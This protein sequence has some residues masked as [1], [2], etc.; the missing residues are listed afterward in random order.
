VEVGRSG[1]I[2]PPHQLSQFEAIPEERWSLELTD[3]LAFPDLSSTVT[4]PPYSREELQALLPA[5]PAATISIENQDRLAKAVAKSSHE[6]IRLVNKERPPLSACVLSPT[7]PEQVMHILT[8]G[9]EHRLKVIP[10]SGGS[11]VTGAAE[12]EEDTAVVLKLIKTV[13]DL[14]QKEQGLTDE[15]KEQ[16]IKRGE[17]LLT[18]AP[19][20]AEEK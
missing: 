3:D 17:A 15:E 6:I 16:E 11:N 8:K 4:D 1:S 19:P 2:L 13:A 12:A 10:Y 18:M 5:L 9:Q 14:F 7:E 20:Q